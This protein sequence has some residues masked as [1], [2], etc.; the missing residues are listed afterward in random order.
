MAIKE[1]RECGA[2]VSTQAKSCPQCGAPGPTTTNRAYNARLLAV[3]IV[4]GVGGYVLINGD[5]APSEKDSAVDGSQPNISEDCKGDLSCLGQMFSVDANY[6]CKQAIKKQ[7]DYSIKWT[8]GWTSPTF[9][10]YAWPNS[11]K[12][13]VIVY[14]GDN[15]EF[16]NQYGAM[17]Q[18]TY[19]CSYDYRE[20][21]AVNISVVPGSR[22]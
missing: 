4:F 1:C 7:S 8:D 6:P 22:S 9:S 20:D 14:I 10:A 12:E 19:Y 11:K 17:Q 5:N 13:G 15:V 18:M 16:E 3:L 21:K 2:S